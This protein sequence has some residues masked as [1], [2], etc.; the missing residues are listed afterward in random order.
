[1]TSVSETQKTFSLPLK[2]AN[3]T[4]I[5]P[6]CG[7]EVVVYLVP[8][9]YQDGQYIKID[10]P[11]SCDLAQ[12]EIRNHLDELRRMSVQT[13]S[14]PAPGVG[15]RYASAKTYGIFAQYVA[16]FS[17]CG[18]YI[19]GAQGSGKT[20][21]ASAVAI[22]IAKTG[23]SVRFVSAISMLD[24]I[25]STY[26]TPTEE[27]YV[28]NSFVHPD[29]LVIDDLGKEQVT[30]WSLSRMFK[31]IDSRYS[32]KKPTVVT[33]ER[34]EQELSAR[35]SRDGDAVNGN[36]IIRR[37]GEDCLLVNMEEARC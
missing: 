31:I 1:M 3:T 4:S 7:G 20:Y 32:S 13:Y 10:A 34:T 27:S 23:K 22:E 5:C 15:E 37:L 29:L 19:F 33:T 35:W 14:C 8:D 9:K 17:Q 30:E 24:E 26:S 6:F 21:A 12:F 2:T 18:L 16:S 36:A 25:K 11:C 28:I